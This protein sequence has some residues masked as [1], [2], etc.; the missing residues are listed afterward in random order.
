MAN[1]APAQAV[2][3][4]PPF[5]DLVLQY[6]IK[7]GGDG[8]AANLAGCSVALKVWDVDRTT[9]YAAAAV[10]WVDQPAG[11]VD[12]TLAALDLLSLPLNQ[13][14]RADLALVDS[15]GNRRYLIRYVLD[16]STPPTLLP[17]LSDVYSGGGVSPE[18]E[19]VVSGGSYA[20]EATTIV[21]GGGP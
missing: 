9:Q 6:Q 11:R 8:S 4:V 16:M 5:G 18:V 10:S 15:L 2:L 13:D 3:T 19:D 21:Y 17:Q 7:S 1:P 14:L 20:G 12:L